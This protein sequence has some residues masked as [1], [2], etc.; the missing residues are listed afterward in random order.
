MTLLYIK[1]KNN[2]ITTS[3]KLLDKIYTSYG[4]SGDLKETIIN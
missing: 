2:Q 4:S 3:V 1:G